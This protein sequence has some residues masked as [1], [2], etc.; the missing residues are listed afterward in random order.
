[1]ESEG[2]EEELIIKDKQG[3]GEEIVIV[4]RKRENVDK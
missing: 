1:M 4:R 3:I 2:K